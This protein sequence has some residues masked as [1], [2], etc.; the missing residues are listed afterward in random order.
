MIAQ[1]TSRQSRRV[2]P[3][4][5]SLLFIIFAFMPVPAGIQQLGLRGVRS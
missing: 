5:F 3:H 2:Y 4:L 1:Q